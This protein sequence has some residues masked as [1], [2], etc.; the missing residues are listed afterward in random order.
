M[1][2]VKIPVSGGSL[3]VPK[4][5]LLLVNS[6]KAAAKLG[7]RALIGK[8]AVMCTTA[9][10]TTTPSF[11]VIHQSHAVVL[12]EAGLAS[13]AKIAGFFSHFWNAC[14]RMFIGSVNQLGPAAFVQNNENPF[15]KPARFVNSPSMGC[16]RPRDE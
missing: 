1:S 13:D 6:V 12:E 3:V 8:A 16:G 2:C 4:S 15:A 11:N 10:V 7:L 9:S 5:I 14:L